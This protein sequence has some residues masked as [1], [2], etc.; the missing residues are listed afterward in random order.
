MKGSQG[1]SKTLILLFVSVTVVIGLFL[2]STYSYLLFH[3]IIE[4]FA[5]L[6]AFAVFVIGWNSTS[7]NKFFTFIGIAYIF[8]AAIDILHTLSYSG[9]G[10]FPEY[11]AN[12]P[13]QLWIIARYIE[14]SAIL[15]APFMMERS[16]KREYLVLAFFIVSSLSLLT[17]FAG[18]FPDCFI[19][20][21]G[22]TPFKIFS[23]Y[24]ISAILVLAGIVYYR[25]REKFDDYVLSLLLG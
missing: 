20:G 19:E 16:T 9:T 8:I 11:N 22:L 3:S 24:I 2:I 5:I 10:I 4:L 21:E 15:I 14:S 12:L 18:L 13:T 25:V 17:I 6:I 23:E 1:L 7:K